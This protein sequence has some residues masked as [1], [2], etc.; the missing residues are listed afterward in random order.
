MSSFSWVN[1]GL[2]AMFAVSLSACAQSPARR[3]IVKAIVDMA[4]ALGVTVLAEGV[5]DQSELLSLRAAGIKLIQGYLFAKPELE[6][7]CR[8][9]EIP[10]LGQLRAAG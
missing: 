10:M 5:E 2:L 8:E 7:F 9:A 1:T 3:I 6:R 4:A